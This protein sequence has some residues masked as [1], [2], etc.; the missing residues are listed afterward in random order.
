MH[1]CYI[2]LHHRDELCCFLITIAAAA[3][4]AMYLLKV[5]GIVGADGTWCMHQAASCASLHLTRQ[6]QD[7]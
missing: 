6:H 3:T 7:I 2:A 4:L 5:V 1:C